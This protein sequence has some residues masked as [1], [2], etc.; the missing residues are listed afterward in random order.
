M[1]FQRVSLRRRVC[2]NMLRHMFVQKCFL[3]WLFIVE[4]LSFS[5]E[6]SLE[7]VIH[8]GKPKFISLPVKF[9]KKNITQHAKKKK[10]RKKRVG[11]FTT[12][13]YP[14]GLNLSGATKNRVSL[15]LLQDMYF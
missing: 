3:V 4:T 12:V 7:F 1:N 10:K 13:G 9:F 5:L 2:F 15:G 6:T 8:R 14:T 11:T